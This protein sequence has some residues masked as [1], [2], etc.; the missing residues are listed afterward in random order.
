MQLYKELLSGLI[1]ALIGGFATLLASWWQH[2]LENRRKKREL[3]ES[4]N[5]TLQAIQA[6]V[7]CLGQIYNESIGHKLEATENNTPFLFYHQATEDYFTVF[8]QNSSL[9]GQIPSDSLRKKIIA[10][11]MKMKSLLD[12]YKN[13]NN[14]LEKYVYYHM[15]FLET[16]SPIHEQQKTTYHNQLLSYLPSIKKS[17]QKLST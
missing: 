14:I 3:N 12:T 17:H 5:A 7:K 10:V 16:N 9:I 15:L 4:L 6:E 8:T 1:G 11:Y 13:N 2:G